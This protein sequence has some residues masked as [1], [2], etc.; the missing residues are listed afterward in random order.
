MSKDIRDDTQVKER[1][2]IM[3]QIQR[4]HLHVGDGLKI[5]ASEDALIFSVAEGKTEQ[6]T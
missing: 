6:N 4:H 3:D 1:I 2:Q 5:E